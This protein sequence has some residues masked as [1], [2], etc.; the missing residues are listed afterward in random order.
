MRF[1]RFLLVLSLLSGVLAAGAGR[2]W[3]L[4]PLAFAPE[5]AQVEFHVPSGMG[6]RGVAQTLNQAGV[7]VH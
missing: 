7:A 6:L 5:V 2:V 1:L 4:R 3:F